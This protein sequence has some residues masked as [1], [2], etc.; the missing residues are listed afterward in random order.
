MLIDRTQRPRSVQQS[1]L[2]NFSFEADNKDEQGS[3]QIQDKLRLD[4]ELRNIGSKDGRTA[5]PCARLRRQAEWSR[6]RGNLFAWLIA[7]LNFY[8]YRWWRRIHLLC[9]LKEN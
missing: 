6:R 2:I 4:I 3:A 1:W 9:R 5:N 7:R 8:R